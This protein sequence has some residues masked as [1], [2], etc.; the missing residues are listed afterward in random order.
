[1]R[2][3]ILIVGGMLLMVS[4]VAWGI[5]S[6]PKFTD[7]LL[8]HRYQHILQ[9]IRCLQC[10]NENIANSDAPLA[11]DFRRQIHAK[12][13]EGE[14]EQQILRYM[15]NRY[16]DFVLYD[17]PLQANTWLLWMAPF[18]LLGIAFVIVIMIVRRRANMDDEQEI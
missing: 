9:E 2:P 6:E 13:A 18:L 8:E 1:M 15:V 5:D 3:W 17:P 16:G 10:M 12:V 4:R 7:P 11:A 14:S